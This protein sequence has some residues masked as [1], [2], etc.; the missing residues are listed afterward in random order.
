MDPKWIPNYMYQK[1]EYVINE[2]RNLYT[3][4]LYLH[5]FLSAE[6]V[7]DNRLVSCIT[8]LPRLLQTRRQENRQVYQ[9]H[10][11]PLVIMLVVFMAGTAALSITELIEKSICLSEHNATMT[12][13][14]GIY[15]FSVFEGL[16]ILFL[17]I[18]VNML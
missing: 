15:E 2:C 5:F 17:L 16:N 4:F 14:S 10:R 9:Q 12:I 13:D 8:W 7:Q 1:T 3:S 11:L 18:Q 6:E